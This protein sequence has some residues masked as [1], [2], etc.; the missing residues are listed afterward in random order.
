MYI[1]RIPVQSSIGYYRKKVRL[2]WY[3]GAMRGGED[4]PA[5]NE[6]TGALVHPACAEGRL[7]RVTEGRHPRP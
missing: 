3:D 4:V 5:T 7:G 2:R 1:Q 6:A